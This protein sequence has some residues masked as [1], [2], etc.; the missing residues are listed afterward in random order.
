LRVLLAALITSFISSH[1][2]AALPIQPTTTLAAETSNNT[3]AANS[4]KTQNNG[5]I[6]AGNVSK[7]PIRDLLYPGSTTKIYVHL[8]PWFG[9]SNHM[10]VGY[11]SASAAQVKR[12]VA[13]MMSRGIDGAIVDWY[14]PES[15]HHDAATMLLMEEAERNPGFEFAI[16][17]DVGS[18]RTAAN[19]QQ[20][21][22]ADLNHVNSVYASSPAY[23]RRGGR[24]VIF[25]FG[26]ETL[27]TPINWDVVRAGVLGNP[28]FIFRNS[29]AFTKPQTNGGFGWMAPQTT[30]TPN[31]M[32][33]DYLDNFYTVALA[34]PTQKTFG[35]GYK[36]FDDS[37]AD[38]GKKRKI[39]HF[40][41]QTWLASMARAGKFYSSGKQLEN[42]QIV[43]WN[44][45][46]EGSEIES[47]IDNCVSIAAWVE[48]KAL[49][50]KITGSENTIAHYTV[51]ISKD[52]Q[53]LMKLAEVAA[54]NRS[55]NLESF[56]LGE[57]TYTLYVKAVGK[58]SIVNRMSNAAGFPA[59][60]TLAA[61]PASLSLRPGESGNITISVT[62]Q[63]GGFNSAVAL[64]CSGLPAP[65]R[66]AF[67]PASVTPGA[68]PAS[69][70]LTVFTSTA[71][72]A[73]RE[74]SGGGM[75]Y[76]F[77]LAG[78]GIF[79]VVLSAPSCGGKRRW[80]ALAALLVALA[81]LGC[82]STANNATPSQRPTTMNGAY[83]VVITGTSG[84]EQFSTTVSVVVQ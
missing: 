35:S 81:M 82:G 50:W 20:K 78:A 29:G 62:P 73:Q 23:M 61:S 27:A 12:Q 4:F 44:D 55:L 28:L 38:W 80:L 77:W 15:T 36:G 58:P 7:L 32:S 48:G 83:T 53:N 43:T 3:S 79:G 71:S 65:G 22:I 31:Y 72:A 74:P 59:K 51:F 75:L 14:G 16:T 26:L 5:N 56:D 39:N 57:N 76:A 69:S 13:D 41:G 42:L 25:F 6:G 17:E 70:N 24:P 54:G 49:S 84:S 9:P 11:E 33:L 63:S 67:S 40:C 10:N 37:L 47:G 21:L 8:M 19:P 46:E 45:Y 1:A 66:C 18:L 52:G 68:Q 2:F 34:H 30:V 64:S 60:V